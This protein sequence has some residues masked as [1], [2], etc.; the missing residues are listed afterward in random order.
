VRPIGLCTRGGP[1]PSP[2]PPPGPSQDPRSDERREGCR[3]GRAGDQRIPG[4]RPRPG[5]GRIERRAD[6]PDTRVD[7]LVLP[8]IPEW[9]EEGEPD[10]L[11][12]L[13][14]EA[15]RRPLARADHPD[16]PLLRGD[17]DVEPIGPGRLGPSPRHVGDP[18]PIE[19]TDRLD[20]DRGAV[21][22]MET[23]QGFPRPSPRPSAEDPAAVPNLRDG[24]GLRELGRG[25]DG[26]GVHAP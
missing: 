19:R 16:V 17:E 22:V 12:L 11:S 18:G 9:P 2:A 7:R 3:D 8:A 20:Q 6:R 21:P 26:H 1:T 24:P 23:P 14:R 10:R 4:A 13:V 25:D 5:R 15:A